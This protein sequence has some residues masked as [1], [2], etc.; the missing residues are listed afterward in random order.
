MA[1]SLEARV[2]FLDYRLVEFIEI[3]AP[4]SQASRLQG[5]YLHK[6]AARNGCR[7]KSCTG[8][9][10]GFAN[11]IVDWLRGAMPPYVQECLFGSD[12]AVNRY[13]DPS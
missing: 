1:N 3:A 10:K 2:P 11:P 4:R 13:F 7:K 8:R 6:K 5:K 12:S 9:R